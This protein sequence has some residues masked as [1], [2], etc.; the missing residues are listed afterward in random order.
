MLFGRSR[1]PASLYTVAKV[2]LVSL[3]KMNSL[4]TLN[5]GNSSN[6]NNKIDFFGK[7]NL[8]LDMS[9]T[10]TTENMHFFTDYSDDDDMSDYS[11][12]YEM[13]N[14]EEELHEVFSEDEDET[15]LNT[16]F[17][18]DMPSDKDQYFEYQVWLEK[19]EVREE[20]LREIDASKFED[21]KRRA[22]AKKA[23]IVRKCV[24]LQRW[25]QRTTKGI[26]QLVPLCDL[27]NDDQTE[28]STMYRGRAVMKELVR[29]FQWKKESKIAERKM[30]RTKMKM[31]K[32]RRADAKARYKPSANCQ[33]PK[34]VRGAVTGYGL[35]D[36]DRL[37]RT[38]AR[39]IRVAKRRAADDA[40]NKAHRAQL[41]KKL[42]PVQPVDITLPI[43]IIEETSDEVDEERKAEESE[44]VQL[45]EIVKAKVAEKEI[46]RKEK[47]VAAK[48][49]A[50]N[51]AFDMDFAMR[52]LSVSTIKTSKTERK[53]QATAQK[54][55]CPTRFIAGN[56]LISQKKKERFMKDPEHAD[57][58]QAFQTLSSKEEMKKV[59][60]KTTMCRS[61]KYRKPCPHGVH[62]R[63]AHNMS[64]L[65]LRKCNFASCRLV[66]HAGNGHYKNQK[67]RGRT[68]ICQFLH[69]LETVE[70][71]C[72]RLGLPYTKP[73][74]VA[75][76]T[77]VQKA[78]APT[79]RSPVTTPRK[80]AWVKPSVPVKAVKRKT[81]WGPEKPLKKS[82]KNA[83]AKPSV[84]V[85]RKTRWGPKKPV[86]VITVPKSCA[87]HATLLALKHGLTN[88]RIQFS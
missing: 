51:R 16:G 78:T 74:V 36:A 22:E 80:N 7:S 85:R 23:D 15:V 83:W 69:K 5:Q 86:T 34:K 14:N 20:K 26:S 46:E 81:R 17:V 62:C 11:S 2:L 40:R 56:G 49:K 6:S 63:F 38:S 39:K 33:R 31:A 77:P 27:T 65:K 88:F 58:S 60:E 10:T 37:Q 1:T 54:K 55:S 44:M 52:F 61:V 32:R 82:R 48:E 30:R 41:A 12:D 72:K 68:K 28:L 25:R 8:D 24:E 19:E 75:S 43:E 42:V 66:H 13:S 35:S 45:R 18:R 71:Y 67:F 87:Q 3:E 50:A 70:A 53:K 73:V 57:R 64:E 79:L 76:V 84:P 9:C 4:S 59:Y 29:Y 47:K 21:E